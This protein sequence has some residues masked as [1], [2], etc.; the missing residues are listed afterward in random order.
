[1]YIYIYIYTYIYIHIYIYIY[2]YIYMYT[3]IY[4]YICI[5]IFTFIFISIFIHYT[6]RYHRRKMVGSSL[7][8]QCLLL[9]VPKYC[10][11]GSRC[12]LPGFCLM[13]SC[14]FARVW[15]ESGVLQ[16]FVCLLVGFFALHHVTLQ[17]SSCAVGWVGVGCI[18]SN[19]ICSQPRK[20]LC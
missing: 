19:W 7:G 14:R 15:A 11:L 13:A 8:A 18:T 20:N 6:H 4:I 16:P 17:T 12:T 5:Y 1:M 9:D 2:I 3:Y 10:F